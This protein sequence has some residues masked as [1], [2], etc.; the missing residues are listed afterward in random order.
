[1]FPGR[2]Q[3]YMHSCIISY[4]KII[5][6]FHTS[7]KELAHPCIFLLFFKYCSKM[8]SARQAELSL[9][10]APGLGVQHAGKFSPTSDA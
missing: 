3:S 8:T 7:F 10:K 1:M 2:D 5:F 4:M 6:N 9:A